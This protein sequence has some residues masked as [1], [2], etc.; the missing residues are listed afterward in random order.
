MVK[1]GVVLTQINLLSSDGNDIK[2]YKVFPLIS[3]HTNISE[4]REKREINKK[5]SVIFFFQNQEAK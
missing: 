3:F 2:F 4:K 1:G 5:R